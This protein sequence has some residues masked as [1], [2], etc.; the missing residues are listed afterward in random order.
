MNTQPKYANWP[1]I[2][3]LLLLLASPE[4][5]LALLA[6]GLDYLIWVRPEMAEA[7]APMMA[8][9]TA[10][11]GLIIGGQLATR[12]EGYNA[13]TF[14]TNLLRP[15]R[16]LL[17]SRKFWTAAGT[18]IANVLIAVI[19]ELEE[20]RVELMALF[21]T[22][23]LGLIGSIAWEDT[24]ARKDVTPPAVMIPQPMLPD[25]KGGADETELVL[26]PNFD[27]DAFVD[28]IEALIRQR[29]H[30]ILTTAS[31]PKG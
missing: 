22:I 31:T 15:F 12:L 6:I 11:F 18:L 25:L 17:Q 5:I 3:P 19:P 27:I 14:W 1:L 29:G 30:T 20:V 23:G 10:L 7:R 16:L 26:P 4:L 13:R 8:V 28:H 21:T 24:A 9:V 2:G